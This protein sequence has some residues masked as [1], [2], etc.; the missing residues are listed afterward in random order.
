M[1]RTRIVA[2][3]VAAACLAGAAWFGSVRWLDTRQQAIE[4]LDPAAVIVLR[5]PGG[6]LEVSQ[7]VKVEEFGW[8][9]SFTCP[10]VDCS[11]W[12][13]RTVSRI[14]VPAH[15]VY[16]I[17]LAQDWTM[18]LDHGAYVLTVPPPELLKPVAIDSTRMEIQTTRGWLAPAGPANVQ[19]MLRAFGPE[20]A[21]RGERASYM[22]AQQAEA[23]KTIREFAAKWMK[24][25]AINVRLP[26]HVRFAGSGAG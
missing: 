24:E 19:A 13:G 7:L 16:R 12:L 17:P 8:Q 22:K 4:L 6:L 14:R 10:L 11:D 18:V 23:E 20:L 2:A 21:A 15:Y 26:V 5:T 9:T 25:Q 3:G 1:K